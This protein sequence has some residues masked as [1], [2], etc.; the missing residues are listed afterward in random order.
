MSTSPPGL[1]DRA[2]GRSWHPGTR[3]RPPNVQRSVKRLA[4]LVVLVSALTACSGTGTEGSL[5]VAGT[6]VSAVTGPDMT[7]P[8]LMGVALEELVTENHTFGEGQPPFTAYLVQSHLDP[9]AGSPDRDHGGGRPLTAAER[10]AIEDTIRPLGP[11]R[12][13]DDPDQWRTDDLRPTIDGAVILGV[14]EPTGDGDTALV[15]VSLWCG[16]LCGT[17][18]TYRL[19]LVDG[20]WQVTGTEGPIAIA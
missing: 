3:F 4:S 2:A 13:I 14:G 17:W 19:T 18:L 15:P 1:G 11:L 10:A 5:G 9:R 7:L 20:T 12:W 16:G 8:Q 6:T